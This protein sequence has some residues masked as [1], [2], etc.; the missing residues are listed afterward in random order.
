MDQNQTQHMDSNQQHS[1]DV[2]PKTGMTLSRA[3]TSDLFNSIK[4]NPTSDKTDLSPPALDF[5][6]DLHQTV[7]SRLNTADRSHSSKLLKSLLSHNVSEGEEKFLDPSFYL[8]QHQ[9]THP[10]SKPVQ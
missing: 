1:E 6:L 10:P 7:V 2:N 9:K 4:P 8:D 3:H 5:Y